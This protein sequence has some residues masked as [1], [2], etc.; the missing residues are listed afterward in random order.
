MA[1]LKPKKRDGVSNTETQPL[2]DISLDII[3]K[4]LTDIEKQQRQE[5]TNG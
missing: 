1:K 3:D 2:N 4:T 5:S